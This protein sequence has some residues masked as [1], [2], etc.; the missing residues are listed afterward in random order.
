[1]PEDECCNHWR[2]RQQPNVVDEF[3]HE[4]NAG[5]RSVR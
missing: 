2:I 3:P 5:F 1:M 4:V